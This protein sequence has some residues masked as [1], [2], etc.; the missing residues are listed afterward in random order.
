M[1]QCRQNYTLS[2][3]EDRFVAYSTRNYG[4]G[5]SFTYFHLPAISQCDHHASIQIDD[6]GT[7]RPTSRQ[8]SYDWRHY[9]PKLQFMA[10]RPTSPLCIRVVSSGPALVGALHST[11]KTVTFFTCKCNSGTYHNRYTQQP[12]VWQLIRQV[13]LLLTLI[14]RFGLKF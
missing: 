2:H 6:Q 7:F 1:L 12:N 10:A 4:H 13:A 3:T 8:Q 14:Q 9:P 11:P 5:A